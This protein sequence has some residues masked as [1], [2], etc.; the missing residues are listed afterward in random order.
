M[1]AHIFDDN[2]IF[3]KTTLSQL[4]NLQGVKIYEINEISDIS[5]IVNNI[6]KSI[7]N[8]D[9]QIDDVFFINCELLLFSKKRQDFSGIEFLKWLRL[10]RI[11][12]HC[13]LYSFLSREQLM[14]LS[15][16][17]LIIFSEGV[18]FLKLPYNFSSL[19]IEK[20]SQK[21]A[22]SDLTAY[23][24]AES[25]L[26]DDRHFFA[27][28][29]GV[30]KLWWFYKELHVIEDIDSEQIENEIFKNAKGIGSYQAFLAE[31]LY[32]LNKKML[33]KEEIELQQKQLII[34]QFSLAK[35]ETISDQSELTTDI[36]ENR[37]ND[38]P[39]SE[40]VINTN[41]TH[42]FKYKIQDFLNKYLLKFGI[43]KY[44]V[45]NE[46]VKKYKPVDFIT[47]NVESKAVVNEDNDS[48]NNTQI[49]N[50]TL[51]DNFIEI[52]NNYIRNDFVYQLQKE[53][54][55]ILYIDDQANEGW[56]SVF[57]LMIYGENDPENNYQV[58]V[59]EKDSNID[60]IIS[61]CY[62]KMKEFE[63]SKPDLVIL[64]LRLQGEK[65]HVADL[66]ELSGIKVLKALKNGYTT[67]INGR[68]QNLKPICCPIM[69]VTAS[70]K[71]S[72]TQTIISKGADAYWI[73]EG[74]DNRFSLND[75]AINYWEFIAKVY[76]L[77]CTENYILLRKMKETFGGFYQFTYWWENKDR[78]K[79]KL[80]TKEARLNTIPK[81]YVALI[82]KDSILITESMLRENLLKGFSKSIS[83]SIPSLLV[84]RL[85]QI[86]EQIHEEIYEKSNKY[87]PIKHLV[88]NHHYNEE[89]IVISKILEI[90]NTSTHNISL[91]IKELELFYDILIKYL[92]TKP[93]KIE[94]VTKGFIP[95]NQKRKK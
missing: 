53:N 19:S 26:P 20:I 83:S 76:T 35:E 42:D 80:Y 68:E 1:N 89:L 77:C 45:P 23:F 14:M 37:L 16:E 50:N 27:N 40:K 8:N 85:F 28:W 15:P 62:L 56:S 24:V 30:K 84:V 52:E 74:L 9:I 64:D 67:S 44:E 61:D 21:Y 29:W 43:K 38:K 65:G 22:P 82:L 6:E 5:V 71:T 58:Y 90:R 18:T 91:T 55:K 47:V 2:H 75:S 46:N 33:T 49:I 70:N 3:L 88:E 54:S 60:T 59:P 94:I 48:E 41:S 92:Q 66:S 32:G 36:D 25:R 34:N 87:I 93:K 95:V 7:K 57:K 73:K 17:N 63:G 39:I 12:N 81:D 10:K 51:Y 69:V 13:V 78:F 31:Y 79:N 86:I 4:T 72:T 11:N